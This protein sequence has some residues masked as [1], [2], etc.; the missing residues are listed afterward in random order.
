[1][2]EHNADDRRLGRLFTITAFT[3]AY[4]GR[5][6]ILERIDPNTRTHVLRMKGPDV[7]ARLSFAPFELAPFDV[8][9]RRYES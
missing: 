5:V 2:R 3:S 4:A 1:M 8:T 6:G 9:L 7:P